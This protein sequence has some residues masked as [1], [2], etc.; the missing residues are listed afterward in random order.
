M[1]GRRGAG[2]EQAP[3]AA[4]GGGGGP[5][6]EVAPGG[7]ARVFQGGTY[8]DLH[9]ML[10]ITSGAQVLYIGASHP[11]IAPEQTDGLIPRGPRLR[12]LLRPPSLQAGTF[13]AASS[14]F[15]TSMCQWITERCNEP[16]GLW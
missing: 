4:E 7:R 15:D 3:A 11:P 16:M 13:A 14:P 5:A 9:R 10:R 2:E 8:L 12:P 6:L 1:R